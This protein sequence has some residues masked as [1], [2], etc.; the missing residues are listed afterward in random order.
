MSSDVARRD[1]PLLIHVGYHKTATTW[2][3]RILFQPDFGYTPIMSH[4]EV[5]AHLVKPHALVFDP[6]PVKALIDARRGRGAAGAADVISCEILSGNPFFGGR[7]SDEY[8]RRLKAVAP[9]ARILLSIREQHRALASLYM[10][11]ISRAGTLTPKAFFADEP[12]MGYF[13][14]APEHFEYHRLVGFY[15]DLFGAENVHVSTQEALVRDSL[16]L[17]RELGGFAGATGPKD[18]SEMSKDP[19]GVSQ[20]ESSAFLLRRINH[21]QS[22]PAGLGP[23]LDLGPVSNLAYRAT[24]A[25]ARGPLKPLLKEVKPVTAFVAKRFAGRYEE[26]NRALK[27]MVGERTDL[28]GYPM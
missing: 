25:L 24:G 19:V 10:Q 23:V 4:E 6:E 26:S 5:F 11:Y 1:A 2:L 28:T 7:E 20:P 16:Q 9:D 27:A 14:F 22:G 8:A 21:F 3:Q 13:A 18:L 12:V 15:R 17:A